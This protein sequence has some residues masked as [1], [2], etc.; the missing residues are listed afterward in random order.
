MRL[1]PWPWQRTLVAAC[2]LL[3][4]LPASAEPAYEGLPGSK[5]MAVVPGMQVTP[6]TVH[7][8]AN[9]LQAA[10]AA[11]R[12]CD[13][14]RSAGSP[15]CELLALNDERITS[16][17]EIRSRAPVREHPLYLW[18]LEHGR[19][20]V[21]LAGS[22]H[23]LKPSLYPLPAPFDEAFEAADTL[24]VEVNVGALDPVELQAKTLSYATLPDGTRVQ[25]ALAAPLLARL[26]TSLDRYGVALSQVAT[27]KPAFLMN[28]VVLLRLASLGYQGEH[29]VEQHYLRKLGSRRLLEL[30]TLDEQLALLFNQPM[31]LQVQLLEDTLDQEPEIEPLV[32]GM[33]GAWFSGDDAL[34]MEMFEA[35]SGDSE[36]ARQFTEQLL[37]QRNHGMADRIASYLAADP[38]AAESRTYFV[39]V[40][41]A[42]LIGDEGIVALLAERG[43]TGE[44]LTS[45]SLVH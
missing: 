32:A 6:V 43:F 33:I 22:V 21:Y 7:G 30:E 1:N 16:G 28:Q 20:R 41:A 34:F 11:L 27:L 19:N 8:Q 37:D 2:L 13:A 17:A 40:G 44:R 24:V 18:R 9:D 45:K 12:T 35:Q 26:E 23:I 10:V 25:S 42:H 38:D 5:A 36:L 3:I 14:G 4:Q 29:G 39:L 31:P 15:A